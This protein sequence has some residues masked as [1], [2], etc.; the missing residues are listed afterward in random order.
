LFDESLTEDSSG[1]LQPNVIAVDNLT[2]DWL[3][4]K[5]VELE[6]EQKDLQSKLKDKEEN[7]SKCKSQNG[8]TDSLKVENRY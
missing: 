1:K 8:Q 4:S 2:L 3:K 6:N 7:L 5:V